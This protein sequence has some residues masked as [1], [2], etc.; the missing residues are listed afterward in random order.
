MQILREFVKHWLFS[1][2]AGE[3]LQNSLILQ[4]DGLVAQSVEQC[5][6]NSKRPILAI[7]ISF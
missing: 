7:F 4:Q 5:P 3:K 6:F 2:S 1:H